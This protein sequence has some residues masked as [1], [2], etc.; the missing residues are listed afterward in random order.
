[1]LLTP[2]AAMCMLHY[3]TVSGM[4]C[5]MEQWIAY[6]VWVCNS[7][8]QDGTHGRSRY[9]CATPQHC[10]WQIL[11]L[12]LRK[13]CSCLWQ[14]SCVRWSLWF[15]LTTACTLR[16]LTTHHDSAQSLQHKVTKTLQKTV[17]ATGNSCIRMEPDF[18]EQQW[19]KLALKTACT[20]ATL[21][22]LMKPT[23]MWQ[24]N[25]MRC[26]KMVEFSFH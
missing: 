15:A 17:H 12:D 23:V 21:R 1:M 5:S 26:K 7:H 20:L 10:E 16:R 2:G 8:C 18:G 24:M 4:E 9:M 6:R 11:T 19:G 22:R 13:H 25:N 3:N 14:L